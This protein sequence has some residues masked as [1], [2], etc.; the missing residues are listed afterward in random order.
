MASSTALF[1]PPSASQPTEWTTT[2]IY[3]EAQMEECY[4]GSPSALAKFK[5][6]PRLILGV[7]PDPTIFTRI[8]RYGFRIESHW[9]Q[10]DPTID[11]TPGE[12]QRVRWS[13]RSLPAR[14]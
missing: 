10:L 12:L 6:P 1:S 2:E 7:D 5:M 3:L 14:R 11:L 13:L 8:L 9:R 4:D